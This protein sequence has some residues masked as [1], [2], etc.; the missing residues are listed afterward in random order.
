[1]NEKT[2]DIETRISGDFCKV[3]NKCLGRPWIGEQY[4]KELTDRLMARLGN[5]PLPKTY[6]I[7]IGCRPSMALFFPCCANT[8]RTV[9]RF[10]ERVRQRMYDL[11]SIE[12]EKIFDEIDRLEAL[13]ELPEN[14]Q[15]YLV[16]LYGTF[17][18]S[19]IDCH[20]ILKE[21]I[22]KI[23]ESRQSEYFSCI[24]EKSAPKPA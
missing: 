16:F 2:Q 8:K 6:I 13:P 10:L 17:T 21:V 9:I 14:Y 5:A 11:S 23:P 22:R 19:K 12:E 1:M 3:F 7:R 20:D 15:L 18:I 4:T 24:L